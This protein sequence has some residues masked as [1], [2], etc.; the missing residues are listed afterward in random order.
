MFGLS[1]VGCG[2]G[3]WGGGPRKGEEGGKGGVE[4]SL[5]GLVFMQA[6]QHPHRCLI[7]MLYNYNHS[8]KCWEGFMPKYLSST[9]GKVYRLEVT[10]PS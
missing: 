10:F 9:F 2:K 5:N 4:S 6:F 3:R 1:G 7:V 8:L